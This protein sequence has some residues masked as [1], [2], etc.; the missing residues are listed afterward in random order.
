M[1]ILKQ[2][3]L[4][5]RQM[6]ERLALQFEDQ[7][8]TYGELQ[9][10]IETVAEQLSITPHSKVAVGF[11]D[12]AQTLIYYFALLQCEAVPCVM[13]PKWSEMQR[14]QILQRYEIEAII[15]SDGEVQ[16]TTS[17]AYRENDE[18]HKIEGLLHIGFTSG[19]TGLPKAYYRNE[20]SW[21]ASY[22]ENERLLSPEVQAIVAPGPLAHSLSLYA[23]IYAL[24][25]GRTFIGMNHFE[26]TKMMQSIAE[27]KAPSA[28]FLV[29]TMLRYSLHAQ[30]I[31]EEC[32]DIF[33]TGDKLPTEI[34]E[35]VKDSFHDA[36]IIEFFGTSEASFIS[37]NYNQQ[38]PVRSVGRC[39]PN[40][41]V[42]LRAQD[43][44]GVGQLF[45]RSDMTFSGYVGKPVPQA[46]WI[47]IGD[48]ASLDEQDHLFLHGRQADRLIIGGRNVY[49]SEIEAQALTHSDISEVLVIGES[50]AQFG[51]IAVMLYVG[52][53]TLSYREFRH[54]M[55]ERCARYQIPSK[56]LRVAEMDYTA[57]GKIARKRMALAYEEG[58]LKR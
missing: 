45:V 28:L 32:V 56:L 7:R 24:Y 55:E 33:T 38:A 43:E 53:R 41:Q 13:D 22:R 14:Q 16:P 54:F 48:Y 20:A 29:P 17:S 11:H 57:S 51:Q 27:V 58:R 10:L 49:P 36:N 34:F 37:Y 40:V 15:Q 26:P 46:M 12:Q 2:L 18:H 3:Q 21:L 35:Q 9:Q 30:W 19:T 4:Y 5:S 52:E 8:F 42:E 25:S 47:P 6:P 31:A 23:C 50:H 39:F 1:E 44:A